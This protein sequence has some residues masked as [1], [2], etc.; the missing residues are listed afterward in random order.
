VPVR[1]DSFRLYGQRGQL[2]KERSV[3][4]LRQVSGTDQLGKVSLDRSAGTVQQGK[5]SQEG[6]PEDQ[7]GQACLEEQVGKISR[8]KSD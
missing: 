2:S 6:Q 4:K 7:P 1:Q 8:G 5:V 3:R